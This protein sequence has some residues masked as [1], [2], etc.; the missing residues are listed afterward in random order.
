MFSR[1]NI[2]KFLSS[3]LI[4]INTLAENKYHSCCVIQYDVSEYCDFTQGCTW[5]RVLHLDA[6]KS[7]ISSKNSCY[8]LCFFVKKATILNSG[9]LEVDLYYDLQIHNPLIKTSILYV[10][11]WKVTELDNTGKCVRILTKENYLI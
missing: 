6:I 7:Q 3:L 5:R 11:D 8:P 4:P 10:K 2:L 1:R 9:V